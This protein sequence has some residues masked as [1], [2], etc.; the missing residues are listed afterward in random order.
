MKQYHPILFKT[1][2]LCV[3]YVHVC[4]YLASKGLY[5]HFNCVCLIANNQD[6]ESTKGFW[7]ESSN[8]GVCKSGDEEPLLA[9]SV[10]YLLIKVWQSNNQ[11]INFANHIL[12][13][14]STNSGE[15]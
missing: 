8:Q 1:F 14:I 10:V 4:G 11:D 2:L 13:P 9:T 7:I 6:Q 15:V 5:S 3:L 12:D